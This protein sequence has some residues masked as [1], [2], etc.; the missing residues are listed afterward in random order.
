MTN[1]EPKMTEDERQEVLAYEEGVINQIKEENGLGGLE[2]M[3]AAAEEAQGEVF[4]IDVVRRGKKFFSFDV[5]PL[6]IKDFDRLEKSNQVFERDPKRGAK[7]LVDF[8]T[9]DFLAMIIFEATTPEHKKEYWS[10]PEVR[11]RYGT[12]GFQS[13][14]QFLKAGEIEEIAAYIERIS[15]RDNELKLGDTLKNSSEQ[16]A[17]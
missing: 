15:G 10:N 7:K 4:P 1:N 2:G 3:F 11:K 13:I 16:A 17:N 9:E 12:I 5:R 6:G 14:P 8:K